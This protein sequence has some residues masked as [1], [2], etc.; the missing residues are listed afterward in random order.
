MKDQWGIAVCAAELAVGGGRER[1]RD[2]ATGR[3]AEEVL[4]ARHIDVG[5]YDGN[6]G[7]RGCAGT[8]GHDH[9]R[10]GADDSRCGEHS[11]GVRM[12]RGVLHGGRPYK[13]KLR[14]SC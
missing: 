2:Q 10:D 12:D 14:F 5:Q 4:R 8:R 13:S 9:R 3:V 1:A 6:A 7:V 11:N